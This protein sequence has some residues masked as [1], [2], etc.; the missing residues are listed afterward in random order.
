MSVISFST[1][2]RRFRGLRRWWVTV[3]VRVAVSRSAA[4]VG[5]WRRRSRVADSGRRWRER[6]QLAWSCWRPQSAAQALGGGLR[7][8][9]V[10]SDVARAVPKRCCSSLAYRACW[11]SPAAALLH[12]IGLVSKASASSLRAASHGAL[13]L[14]ALAV[15]SWARRFF[16]LGPNHRARRTPPTAHASTQQSW[17]PTGSCALIREAKSGRRAHAPTPKPSESRPRRRDRLE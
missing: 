3:C 14:S 12:S 2:R 15:K 17:E 4:L 11:C 8:R 9:R 13:T 5:L 1:L 6:Q 10:R 7:G 16:A